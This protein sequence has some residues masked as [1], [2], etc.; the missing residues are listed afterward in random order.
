MAKNIKDSTG[1][2]NRV[3]NQIYLSKYE[4]SDLE[5]S[6][7][8]VKARHSRSVLSGNLKN[9]KIDTRLSNHGYDGK[10]KH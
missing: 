1:L 2:F 3:L 10:L 8:T 6:E 9:K 5:T 7:V 4:T